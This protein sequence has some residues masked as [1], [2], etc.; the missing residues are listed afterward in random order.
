MEVHYIGERRV[1]NYGGGGEKA[2]PRIPGFPA[3][4]GQWWDSGGTVAGH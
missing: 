4:A 2:V 1:F 3:T